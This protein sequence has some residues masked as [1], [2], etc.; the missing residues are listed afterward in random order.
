MIN[1]NAVNPAEKI[2]SSATVLLKGA[3]LQLAAYSSLYRNSPEDCAN[4]GDDFLNLGIEVDAVYGEL[5]ERGRL[6]C[7]QG[8]ADVCPKGPD[9]P[10]ENAPNLM[11]FLYNNAN[12]VVVPS[13]EEPRNLDDLATMI[14]GMYGAESHV[15]FRLADDG[16]QMHIT[17]GKH[18]C[19]IDQEVVDWS[20]PHAVLAAAVELSCS[21]PWV[22]LPD[23]LA[24]LLQQCIG[25]STELLEEEPLNLEVVEARGNIPNF[26]PG[27]PYIFLD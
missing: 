9:S 11:S 13:I 10:V 24:Y 17:K 7:P 19:T 14:E 27:E 23:T 5:A 22:E 6:I 2:V 3:R 26:T 21:M 25:Y 1:I 15:R 16:Q 8:A 20:S 18:G 12:H 4:P